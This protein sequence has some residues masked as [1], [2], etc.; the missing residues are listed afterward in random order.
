MNST[1]H[2][3]KGFFGIRQREEVVQ[4][5]AADGAPGQ[6]FRYQ[7]RLDALD[8]CTESAKMFLVE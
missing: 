3:L 6:M 4:V 8:Q 5:T 1:H 7:G 2:V